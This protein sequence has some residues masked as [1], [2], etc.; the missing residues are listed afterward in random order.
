MQT[1][2]VNLNDGYIKVCKT[3]VIPENSCKIFFLD[4]KEIVVFKNNGNF[5]A[6]DN[7]C[8]HQNS[9]VLHQGF[10]EDDHLVC[11]NHLFMFNLET[12]K[13]KTTGLKLRKHSVLLEDGSIFVKLNSDA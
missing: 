9:P 5:F 13:M 3:E 8:P 2:Q 12:G 6:F 7:N 10:I 1:T 11:P 4:D